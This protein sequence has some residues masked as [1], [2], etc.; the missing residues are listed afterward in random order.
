M[1]VSVTITR[2]PFA[3]RFSPVHN[4]MCYQLRAQ[5]TGSYTGKQVFFKLRV[6][7]AAT[8]IPITEWLKFPI[9]GT[10]SYWDIDIAPY[11]RGLVRTKKPFINAGTIMPDDTYL[12]TVTIEYGY[13]VKQDC[14]TLEESFVRVP[15]PQ[16]I[17]NAGI[18]KYVFDQWTN[19]VDGAYGMTTRNRNRVWCEGVAERMIIL[20]TTTIYRTY[21][22]LEGMMLGNDTLVV[23]GVP[24][25][26]NNVQ[27]LDSSIM[28]SGTEYINM[29]FYSSAH[30]YYYGINYTI[31]PECFDGDSLFYL[32]QLGSYSSFFVGKKTQD[33][34]SVTTEYL[35]TN[36]CLDNV[37]N[38]LDIRAAHIEK[39]ASVQLS[40][41]DVYTYQLVVS[42]DDT[43]YELRCLLLSGD[44]YLK[45]K[46]EN[47]YIRVFLETTETDLMS[48]QIEL[49]VRLSDEIVVNDFE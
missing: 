39:S 2:Q 40:N 26:V 42:D 5:V 48:D 12:K 31:C 29:E 3:T 9:I 23:S 15:T 20:G 10:D 22:T 13:E 44:I 47:R 33:I 18:D 46:D 32:D 11:L 35:N 4:S 27:L 24:N 25:Y 17:I 49:R 16:A 8:L 34:L 43:R 21:Y 30:G 1:P 7:H 14:D 28:P 41:K 36:D 6:I 19:I 38:I 37:S 45:P